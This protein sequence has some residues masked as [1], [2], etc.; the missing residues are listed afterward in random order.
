MTKSHRLLSRGAVLAALALLAA[1]AT[2]RGPLVRSDYD[3]SVDFAAYKTF[4][5]PEN[6]GT[7]R[8]GYTTLV[9]SHFKDAVRR[10]MTLRGYTYS[11]SSPQ[12]LVNF[13]QEMRDRTRVYSRPAW[14]PPWW[15][16][17]HGFYRPR[18]G[19]YSAWPFFYDDIDVVQYQT[20][21]IR[22]DVID[23]TRKQVVWEASVEERLTDQAQDNPQPMIARLVTELFRKFPRAGAP[24]PSAQ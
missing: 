19:F 2:Q 3:R 24:S 1:C 16:W 14:G 17:G 11:E 8:G 7:D 12:L 20:G 4:G 23:A 22:V 21:T 15:G 6:T 13:Y 18:Y 9:S 5:F 10:E